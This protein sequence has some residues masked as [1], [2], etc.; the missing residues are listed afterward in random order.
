[1][2][3]VR[4]AVALYGAT[5]LLPASVAF[6]LT[7]LRVLGSTDPAAVQE[8]TDAAMLLIVNALVPWW[9]T[10]VEFL[11][12]I[13]GAIGAASTLAFLWFAWKSGL[14]DVDN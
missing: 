12:S 2:S 11:S 6:F 4:P 5:T 14:L 7:Y 8:V 1:M 9:I 13:P 3:M 10:P